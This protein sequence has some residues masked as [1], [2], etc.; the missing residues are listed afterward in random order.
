MPHNMTTASGMTN[1][2]YKKFQHQSGFNVANLP[3]NQ[4]QRTQ[5]APRLT[6]FP[7]S[8]NSTGSSRMPYGPY[9]ALAAA[10]WIFCGKKFVA[11]LFR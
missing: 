3:F 6:G 4:R 8:I 1:V 7:L 9:I 5:C 11:M 10:I 2:S